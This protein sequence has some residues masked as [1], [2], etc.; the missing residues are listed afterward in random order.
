MAKLL[1]NSNRK[2][3]ASQRGKIYKAPEGEGSGSSSVDIVKPIYTKQK[4]PV[5]NTGY[6]EKI[7]FNT[8][9]TPDQVDALIRNANLTLVDTGIGIRLYPILSTN[10]SLIVI[11]DYAPVSGA[12][13]GSAWGIVDL[14][15]EII[16][17]ASPAIAAAGNPDVP[18][19]WEESSFN[20]FDTGEIAIRAELIQEEDGMTAGSQNNLITDLVCLYSQVDTGEVETVKTLSNQYKLIEQNITLD[21]RVD[22][23]SYSYD[24]INNINEDTKEI[25]AIKNIRFITKDKENAIIDRTVTTYT[26]NEVK[27]IGN[28][29]FYNCYSLTNVSFPKATKV[30]DKAFYNC[31]ILVDV[32]IPL[33]RSIRSQAFYNCA[34]LTKVFLSQTT[35]MCVLEGENTFAG[36]S[37]ILG[38][39]DSIH[40]PEGLKDGYIYVPASWLSKYKAD[41]DWEIYA[42]QIIGHEYLEA[43]ATL[44][45]Y[46]TFGFHTQ[47]WYSD[48]KLTTI[49]TSVATSG[50][51][52]CRLER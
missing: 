44:P 4:I 24:F 52:Y 17:Y 1:I 41:H 31:S 28:A 39:K 37:H 7:F 46:T 47:T 10:T 18:V 40:N 48:E 50:T 25:K 6:L 15:H 36:C 13:S 33:V 30:G 8:K 26:N 22:G 20:V 12:E 19:G 14:P 38:T 27:T 45:D 9:L 23:T 34:S 43:G 3:L 2:V 49:V 51:Y 35:F 42:S 21:A 16:Y 29:A 11:A 32:D 5:P